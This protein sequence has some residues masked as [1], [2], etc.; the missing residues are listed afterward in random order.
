MVFI[1]FCCRFIA[2]YLFCSDFYKRGWLVN[3]E[4]DLSSPFAAGEIGDF[5]RC[6]TIVCRC[7]CQFYKATP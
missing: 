5:N 2:V 3:A 6:S 1:T 4:F 7:I